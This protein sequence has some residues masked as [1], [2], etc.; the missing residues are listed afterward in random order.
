MKATEQLP[1]STNISRSAI[2]AEFGDSV[3]FDI[4]LARLTSFRTGGPAKYF[5]VVKTLDN[6]ARAISSAQRLELPCFIVGGG[7]NLLISDAGYDG[8]IIKIEIAGLELIDETVIECGAGESLMSVVKFSESESLTG[9]E[10]AAGIWGT[11]GGAVYGNAGAFGNEIGDVVHELELVNSNGNIKT[12]D[13]NYCRFAYR[14]SY[15]KTTKEVIA[16]VR[17]KLHKGKRDEI[18]KKITDILDVRRDKHPDKLTAGCFFKNI[19]DS[20][21]PHGKLSAGYLLE[22]VGAKELSVGGAKV[23][24]KHANMIINAGDA[25]SHDIHQLAALMKEQVKKKFNIELEEEITRIGY[26]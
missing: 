14:D 8:L 23:F 5:L 24:E 26:F 17:I 9:L 3:E 7:S 10:F 22:E 15:L 4:S 6:V 16:T 2:I 18:Q 21:Q 1:L 13:G 25:T 11:I 20:S 12:V 19:P